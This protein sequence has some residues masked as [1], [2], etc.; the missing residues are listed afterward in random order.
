MAEIALT[1][2]NLTDFFPSCDMNGCCSAF[3][4]PA[5]QEKK[6]K[7]N[8]KHHHKQTNHKTNTHSFQIKRQIQSE[9]NSDELVSNEPVIHSF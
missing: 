9:I 1:V 4:L 5:Y 6:T 3:L 8:Q 2:F 7:P